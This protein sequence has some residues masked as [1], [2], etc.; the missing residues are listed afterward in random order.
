MAK[1]LKKKTA[2]KKKQ[3]DTRTT[4][5][6]VDLV[7]R[8]QEMGIS[9]IFHPQYFLAP[10]AS[11]EPR[12][13]L[14]FKMSEMMKMAEHYFGP[15]DRSYSFIGL[16]FA[17]GVAC[18]GIIEERKETFIQLGLD[19]LHNPMR[20]YSQ[21]AHECVHVLAPDYWHPVTVLEEGLA[22]YFAEKYMREIMHCET[23][24]EIIPSYV[25]A[26]ELVEQLLEID[27]FV[28]RRIRENERIIPFR[29][30]SKALLLKYC[31]TLPESIAEKLTAKFVRD[32][33]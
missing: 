10:H 12:P 19:A 7:K 24:F 20:A 5:S 3:V 15:R 11:S 6:K 9:S 25:A 29:L 8:T 1:Q 28:I 13:T 2:H 17:A 4:Y 33:A 18:N 31:P 22:T 23:S 14:A 21:M 27:Q 16:E 32:T 26:V 30:I